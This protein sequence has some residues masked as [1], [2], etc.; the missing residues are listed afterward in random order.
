MDRIQD[1]NARR[2]DGGPS[3]GARTQVQVLG[4]RGRVH[5]SR[6]GAQP[7]GV[8]HTLTLQPHRTWAGPEVGEP[9]LPPG[10]STPLFHKN[11]QHIGKSQSRRLHKMWTRLLT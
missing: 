3:H 2:T 7:G 4:R 9:Q 8:R 11:T 6:E 10:V 5:V 1:G